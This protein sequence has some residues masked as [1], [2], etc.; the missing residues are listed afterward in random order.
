MADCPFK[1]NPPSREINKLLQQSKG[2]YTSQ[3]SNT[4]HLRDI[5]RFYSEVEA[6]VAAIEQKYTTTRSREVHQLLQ[7][8][9]MV[10]RTLQKL[11]NKISR[12]LRSRPNLAN[13]WRGDFTIDVAREVFN[14]ISCHIIQS[15]NFGH[16]FKETSACIDVAITDTRKALFIF[17]KMN[18]D[19]VLIARDDLLK[20]YYGGSSTDE[21][22]E[23]CEVVVSQAKPFSLKYHKNTEVLSVH[24][25]YGYWNQYGIP[26]H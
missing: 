23:R 6:A 19:G 14:V 13:P 1:E 26:Q 16:Q 3:T 4:T 11:H 9:G 8:Q 5:S 21:T 17:N 20:K 22:L 25:F 24:F 2:R 18:L 7:S 15:N 12:R 10:I